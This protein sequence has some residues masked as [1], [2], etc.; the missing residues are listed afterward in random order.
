VDLIFPH[1]PPVLL[2]GKF[3]IGQ[4]Q[5]SALTKSK[6]KNLNWWNL[7]NCM[8]YTAVLTMTEPGLER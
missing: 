6:N 5:S 2:V 4:W 8:K 3:I 7:D 1:S